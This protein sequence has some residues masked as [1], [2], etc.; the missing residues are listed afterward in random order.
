MNCRYDVRKEELLSVQTPDRKRRKVSLAGALAYLCGAGIS[1]FE[2]LQGHQKQGWYTF[3]VQLGALALSRGGLDKL[4]TN[5][6][7]WEQALLALSNDQGEPWCLVVDD[8]AKPAFF[9]SPI[10][11][12]ALEKARYKA[13]IS[14]PD[15]LDTLVTSKNHD[16]KKRRITDPSIQH[17]I[18]S[19]V[20][21]Q[22]M[23]GFLGRG[24]YGIARMNGG[25]GNRPF[26]GL[27][28]ALGWG[29]RFHR[30]VKMLADGRD[31]LIRER[32]SADGP[33]LL[34][35]LPWDG[36]KKSGLSLPS[37]DPYFIEICRR[38]RF[39]NEDDQLV[40]W[41][42]N[43]KAYRIDTPS[44]LNGVTGDP[45]TPIDRKENKALTLSGKGYDY[46]IVQQLLLGGDYKKPPSLKFRP[47]EEDGGYLIATAM[48]RG[49]GQ[50]EG[51]HQRVI[52][53]PSKAVTVFRDV[54]SK[55]EQL[56]NTARWRVEMAALVRSKL[57]TQGVCALLKIP[58]DDRGDEYEKFSRWLDA[59]ESAVD[60]RFFDALWRT[61]NLSEEKSK[62]IW[63][64]IL[65]DEARMQF[66]DAIASAPIADI[67]RLRIISRA[68]AIFESQARKHL[69]HHFPP[70]K[71]EED[72]DESTVV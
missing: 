40:V 34:W 14:A 16:I 24:N 71:Q 60:T 37:L 17:W 53:I 52:P 30:D 43:S 13:D 72:S 66:D 62:K 51:L 42:A 55:R 65:Y 31:E 61:L 56:A 67:S 7:D 25:F 54:P 70:P 19:L 5:I 35:T 47:S 68:E 32:Y 1:S 41:R 46:K 48:V 44:N 39:T 18:Y 8:I 69:P 29:D 26:V 50:T 15:G 63:E 27:T 23:E 58:P 38:I 22:T 57:V 3:I 33:A 6:S 45:W 64:G 28:P 4:T 36:G 49:K 9:Q 21:L 12:G 2:A 10:P 11:E 59:Y 20:N